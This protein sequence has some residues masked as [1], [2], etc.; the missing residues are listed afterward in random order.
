M[1]FRTIV[2][3]GLGVVFQQPASALFLDSSLQ[4]LTLLAIM[5]AEAAHTQNLL[6]TVQGARIW[7]FSSTFSTKGLS[8]RD[9]HT[10]NDVVQLVKELRIGSTLEASR[11]NEHIVILPTPE[12]IGV[13]LDRRSSDSRTE[14]NTLFNYFPFCGQDWSTTTS[15]RYS[16][17][18]LR[19]SDARRSMR[20][21]LL[22]MALLAALA[23]AH[24]RAHAQDP[25]VVGQFYPLMNWYANATQAV[26]LPNGKVL[27]WPSYANGDR[28]RIWDPVALTNT[29]IT[30]AGYNI[31]CSSFSVLPNGQV[32][33]T[34][35]D[36]VVTLVGLPNASIYDPVGGNWT[37][38][39][40]MNAGRFY[41]TNTVLPNGD[42]VVTS[43]EQ[44]PELGA[45]TLPQVWQVSSGTWRDLTTAQLLLPNYPKMHLAPNGTLF[46]AGPGQVTRYLNTNGTGSWTIGPSIRYGIR[47]Y[48]PSV[49]YDNGKIM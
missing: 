44:S 34:G 27:W 45:D 12:G 16:G 46:Y 11:R 13:D 10:A 48:G 29:F 1:P 49:M 43:G 25:S 7:L 14:E 38:L 30:P 8:P 3:C 5:R 19:P 26:L 21:G 20:Q 32:F 33:I 17:S 28:A 40:N 22:W 24:P 47:D 9:A 2:A 4:C 39:P 6:C 23:G 42:V 41:P 31:F 37:F 18:G 36:A 15:N 35:G